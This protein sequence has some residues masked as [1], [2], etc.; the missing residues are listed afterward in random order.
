MKKQEK[1][2][3]ILL[4]ND[5]W[6]IPLKMLIKINSIF[7]ATTLFVV[8]VVVTNAIYCKLTWETN[9]R[10][11][12]YAKSKEI[13]E[14]KTAMTKKMNK[15]GEMRIKYMI[16]FTNRINVECTK[17]GVEYKRDQ[18]NLFNISMIGIMISATQKK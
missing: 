1:N 15:V 3:A 14:S 13:I 2:A 4:L 8:I 18:I 17:K 6:K 11:K 7:T 12:K 10:K 9:E 16:L 5:D